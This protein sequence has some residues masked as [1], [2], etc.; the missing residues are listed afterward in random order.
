MP[1]P[2]LEDYFPYQ[3]CVCGSQVAR[4]F[5]KLCLAKYVIGIPEWCV[6]TILRQSGTTLTAKQISE[7][8]RMHK[9]KVSRAVKLLEQ[10]KM[11]AG[12]ANP[13]D[14]RETF[15]S[16]TALGRETCDALSVPTIDFAHR[17]AERVDPQDRAPFARAI[18]KLME[19]LPPVEAAT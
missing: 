9:T 11:L 13:V 17:L 10:R 16:L 4:E 15:L 14:H 8:Y 3:L 19:Q 5:E 6:L 12:H 7:R 1:V 2:I 18:K